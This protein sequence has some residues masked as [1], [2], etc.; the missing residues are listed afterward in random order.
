MKLNFALLFFGGL[1]IMSACKK[2]ENCPADDLSSVIVGTWSVSAFGQV[3]G[4]V[5]FRADGTLIDQDDVLIS[6]ESNGTV[7]EDKTYTVPSNQLL[8]VKASKDAQFVEADITVTSFTCD[9][10][11]LTVF[12]ISATLRRN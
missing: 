3:S 7:L 6:G 12:G 9:E 2:D 4:Q 10:V 8:K 5:E 11:E 1:L